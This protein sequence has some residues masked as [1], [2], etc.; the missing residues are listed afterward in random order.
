MFAILFPILAINIPLRITSF[1][2]SLS[3][4]PEFIVHIFAVLI[5]R[6]SLFFQKQFSRVSFLASITLLVLLGSVFLYKHWLNYINFSSFT[7]VVFEQNHV[8]IQGKDL[9]GEIISIEDQADLWVLDFWTTSCR[10]CI[11]EFPKVQK[12][13]D[14]YKDSKDVKVIS[15]NIPLKRDTDNTAFNILTSRGYTFKN[16]IALDSSLDKKLGIEVF[17]TTLLLNRNGQILFRGSVSQIQ[18]RIQEV[19]KNGTKF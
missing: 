13:N 2:D 5:A 15:I 4:F 11:R 3:T 17:P 18:N 16:I 6:G 9:N 14:Q 8:P 19:L 12:L 7:G 1:Q 10:V